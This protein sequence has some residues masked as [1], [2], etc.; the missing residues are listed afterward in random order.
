MGHRKQDILEFAVD[1]QWIY[2]VQK[3][4]SGRAAC[5]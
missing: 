5:L 3:Q 1:L 4:D 2:N